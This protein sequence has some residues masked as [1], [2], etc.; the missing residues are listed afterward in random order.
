MKMK[1]IRLDK[2]LQSRAYINEDTVAEYAEHML[3]G[4]KF[5]PVTLFF[6]SVYYWLADGYHRYYGY[7]KAG[8]EDIEVEVINGTRR[9]AILY[10]LGANSKHGLPRSND[11]KRK[12]VMTL[13][14]DMEW[15]EWADREIA[16]VC[17]VSN[18]TVSRIKKS[19][20]IA[21][22]SEKKYIKDGVEKVMKTDNIGKEVT[23]LKPAEVFMED[24]KLAEMAVAHQELADENAKLLDKIQAVELSDDQQAIDDKFTEY[25]N[26]IKALEAELRAV[27][28]SR[29]QFQQKNAELIKQVAYWRKKAEKAEKVS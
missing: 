11:D 16:R 20:Q 3:D 21:K 23:S 5:P 28:N 26:Q 25:R 14:D 22:P 29:D 4:A 27:K 7:K 8:I 2:D 18:M 9:D 19:L 13:L 17:G 1:D 10:S 24:D 15:C 6:D 12:A